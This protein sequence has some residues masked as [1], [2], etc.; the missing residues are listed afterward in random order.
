MERYKINGKNGEVITGMTTHKN[1]VTRCF[2]CEEEDE[3]K[4]EKRSS[5]W[6]TAVRTQAECIKGIHE[7]QNLTHDV[8]IKDI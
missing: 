7:E 5:Y 6:L 3:N 1:F 4:E 2:T 8:V